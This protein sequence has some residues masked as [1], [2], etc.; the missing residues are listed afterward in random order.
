MPRRRKEPAPPP[1]DKEAPRP[2]LTEPHVIHPTAVYRREAARRAL[3]LA[4]N[5]LTREVR[6]GRLRVARRCAR[7]FF[8]GEW[9]LE[10]LRAAELGSRVGAKA[11]PAPEE[12]G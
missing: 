11:N 5:S 10:W 7:Y 4:R 9:L 3:G 8:L 2:Q 6:A 1:R 12:K